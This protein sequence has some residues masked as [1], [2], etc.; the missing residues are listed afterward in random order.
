M[1]KLFLC[2]ILF[3]FFIVR[4]SESQIEDILKKIPGVEDIVF[5]PAVT[6]SIK[7]AYPTAY[8]LGDIDKQISATTDAYFQPDISAGYY[9][10]KFNTFCLHAGAYAPTEGAGYLVAPLK[11]AKSGLIKNILSRYV[12]HQEIDQRD[13]QRLIWGIE[14]NMKFTDY[15]VEFQA[16]VTP[17]LTSE[18]IAAM[19]VDVKQ[20]AEDLLPQ[21]VKDLLNLYSNLRTELTNP[22]STYE[23]IEQIAVKTGIAPIGKGSRNIEAG[24]WTSIGNNAF[25]RCYPHG[26]AKTDVELYIPSSVEVKKDDKNRIVSLSDGTNRIDITYDVSPGANALEGKYPIYRFKSVSLT[27]EGYSDNM[28]VS[29]KGWYIPSLTKVSGSYSRSDDP[30]VQE[31]NDRKKEGKDFIKSVKKSMSKKRRKKINKNSWN[32]LADLKQ[33]ELSLKPLLGISEL[34]GE[35]YETNYQLAVNAVNSYAGEITRGKKGSGSRNKTSSV[36]MNGLVFAPGNT[37]SQRLGIGNGGPSGGTPPNN[38]EK[39]KEK[40]N[41]K[42]S[43]LIHQVNEKELPKPDWVYTVTADIFI[44]GDENCNAEKI[45]FTLYD[46]SNEPGRY[47]NDKDK[48]NDTE[49]D[50]QMSDMNGDYQITKTTATK[51]LSGKSQT[52]QVYIWCGDYG[53]YGKLKASVLVGGQWYEADAD[54]TPDKYITIPLDLND[55]KIADSW[56]KDNNVYG[57]PAAWDEEDD[58]SGQKT[59]GD[60]MTNYEEYRGFFAAR[61]NNSPPEY[62][63]LNPKQ[64]EMFVID[65]GKLLPKIPWQVASGINVLYLTSNEV[66]GNLAGGDVEYKYRWV[67]FCSNYA[68]G[69]KYAINIIKVDNLIDPYNF[70]PWP[71]VALAYAEPQG[72][73]SP[74]E[75][76]RVVVFPERVRV[77]LIKL[78]DTLNYLV[79]LNPSEKTIEYNGYTFKKT[80]VNKLTG[81]LGNSNTFDLFLQY[82]MTLSMIHEIGHAIGL[83]HHTGAR[84]EWSGAEFCP[85]RYIDISDQIKWVSFLKTVSGPDDFTQWRFCKS[86]DNCW[87]KINVN[88]R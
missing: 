19:S 24:T 14:A 23:D 60:G 30:S 62:M 5:K 79:N 31:Y 75:C 55:N 39:N 34:S 68:K 86:P 40:K 26:Y 85:M 25:I 29:D 6:T 7:D 82:Q 10:F 2:L 8:W 16:R 74:K 18:E 35:W 78:K 22:L 51:Q 12:Q 48:Y 49:P 73:K 47:M 87:S 11:G 38:G 65:E 80:D 69:N 57:L 83:P 3:S 15:P 17:L 56:E 63:R 61:F 59:N 27:G 88:D 58:P 28:T 81:F 36:D 21:D 44:D 84:N 70:Y 43:V 1:K 64:K 33:L 45:V 52:Q 4:S 37:S 66:Y 54:G 67:D 71:S 32:N 41:C 46:V 50:L 77:G 20:I 53:A 13:V 72:C 76:K 9:K 42:V